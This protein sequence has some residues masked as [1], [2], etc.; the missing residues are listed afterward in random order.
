MV[1]SQT[2]SQSELSRDVPSGRAERGD[3]Y[4]VEYDWNHRDGGVNEG[5]DDC[6]GEDDVRNGVPSVAEA[7]RIRHKKGYDEAEKLE[8]AYS[9]GQGG[10]TVT[11]SCLDICTRMTA[12][13][14]SL[15][16]SQRL[17]AVDRDCVE[18]RGKQYCLRY[19]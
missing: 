3:V 4:L 12:F 6:S 11:A 5:A 16:T 7:L 2:W 14:T 18:G 9:D 15:A 19:G 13:P 8:C 1:L 10:W 17:V